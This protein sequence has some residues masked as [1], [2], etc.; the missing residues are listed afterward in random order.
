MLLMIFFIHEPERGLA[1]KEIGAI[2][3]QLTNSN[4]LEDLWAIIRKYSPV[5]PQSNDIPLVP[6]I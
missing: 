5:C 4:Y 3:V 6:L 2:N 1:E